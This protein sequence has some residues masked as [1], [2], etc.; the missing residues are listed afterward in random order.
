MS[1][2]MQGLLMVEKP[3]VWLFIAPPFFWWL[4]CSPPPFGNNTPNSFWRII[5]PSLW[6]NLMGKSMSCLVLWDPHQTNQ[7]FFLRPSWARGGWKTLSVFVPWS[8]WV[9]IFAPFWAFPNLTPQLSQLETP[10]LKFWSA[11]QLWRSP[12]L[13]LSGCRCKVLESFVLFLSC[14]GKGEEL[15]W[16]W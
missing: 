1:P 6:A 3:T 7:P 14:R 2:P 8:R 12:S 10:L 16:E 15:G 13:S 9:F 5:S 11:W 4:V